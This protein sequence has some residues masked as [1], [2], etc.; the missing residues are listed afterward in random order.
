MQ[1]EGGVGDDKKHKTYTPAG[2]QRVQLVHETRPSLSRVYAS[3][4]Q[5]VHDAAQIGPMPLLRGV[6]SSREDHKPSL[7]THGAFLAPRT[8]TRTFLKKSY[9]KSYTSQT[10]QRG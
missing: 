1:N 10:E 3:Y 2:E 5:S 8:H 4:Q 9:K 7:G 6:A